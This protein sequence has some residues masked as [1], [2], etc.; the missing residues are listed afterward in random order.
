MTNKNG[1]R[2][3]AAIILWCHYTSFKTLLYKKKKRVLKQTK[4]NKA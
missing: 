2:K 4:I 3:T 1:L